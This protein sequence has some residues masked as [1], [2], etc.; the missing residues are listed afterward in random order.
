[1]IRFSDA[2]VL[3]AT[4]LRT[5]KI[6]TGII[7][8]VSGL[9]FGLLIGVIILAQGVFDSANRYNEVGLGERYIVSLNEMAQGY[10]IFEHLEDPEIIKKVEAART[11]LVAKKQA[12]AKKY[13]IDY[14]PKTEDP[15]PVTIDKTNGTK[16]ISFENVSNSAVRLVGE[17]MSKE[18]YKPLEVSGMIAKYPSAKIIGKHQ[19]L[20]PAGDLAYM[21]EGKEDWTEEKS[22][23]IRPSIGFFGDS[24][25]KALHLLP[26]SIADPFVSVT[27]F[28]PNAGELPV[29]VPY[30]DAEKLLGLT[31]L[32]N[33]ASS[34]EKRSR[35]EE[36]KNR[37]GEIKLSYCYRNTASLELLNRAKTIK[38]EIE[39]NKNNKDY[40]KPSLIYDVPD[41]TT[42]GA[43]T[44]NSDR[45]TAAEKKADENSKLYQQ[46]IG[47]YTG[48]PEQYKLALRAV[49]V[50][51]DIDPTASQSSVSGLINMTLAS[52]LGFNAWNIPLDMLNKVPDSSKPT[53]VFGQSEKSQAEQIS[54]AAN[55]VEF[56]NPD[57]ARQFMRSIDPMRGDVFLMPF[58]SSSL[59]IEEVKDAFEK[60]IFWVV[61]VVGVIAALI[62]SGLVGRTIADSRRETAVFRS[63]GATRLDISSIYTLYTL[64]FSFR[65]AIFALSVGLV[66]ALAINALWSQGATVGA[67]IAFGAIGKNLQF[68]FI[69]LSSIYIPVVVGVI[70][71]V[72]LVSVILPLMRNVRRN[73]I[74]DMRDE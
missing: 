18:K 60:I 73:P 26:Q 20:S 41:P 9:L 49:G 35:M 17:Q 21:K 24:D 8:G 2:V 12:A 68:G 74:N 59:M 52:P 29:I 66:S 14:E 71:L 25:V 11:E 19:M 31:N 45:R 16:F 38:S 63:I 32:P 10:N 67:D 58:G 70:L 6:R 54:T 53:A 37:V 61:V 44:V 51:A 30:S 28:D 72:G 4:K 27:D 5:H 56:A 22:N 33:T 62:L 7:T 39:K 13:N 57:E 1:M 36:V 42:C 50:S 40:L 34:E 69:S 43:V 64:I 3:A 65:V 23:Q 15:N 48:D 47:T 46:E 55:L